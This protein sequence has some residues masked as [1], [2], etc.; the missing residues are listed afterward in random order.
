MARAHTAC[1]ATAP[2]L[3]STEFEKSVVGHGALPA[4]AHGAQPPGVQP[5][6]LQEMQHG[7]CPPLRQAEELLM[8]QRWS[9]SDCSCRSVLHLNEATARGRQTDIGPGLDRGAHSRA[10]DALE[11][12][13]GDAA[14]ANPE[15]Y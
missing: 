6:R 1:T 12:C 3:D 8:A 5:L 13:R 9:S 15:V 11:I 10:D 4:V 14:F 2:L 7:A